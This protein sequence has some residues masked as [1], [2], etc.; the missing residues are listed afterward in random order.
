MISALIEE[1]KSIISFLV[2][3]P[4]SE[5]WGDLRARLF[6][7][8]H[9]TVG[10]QLSR[11]KNRSSSGDSVAAGALVGPQQHIVFAPVWGFSEKVIA[12]EA[13]LAMALRLRGHKVSVL[14]CGQALPACLWNVFGNRSLSTAGFSHRVSSAGRTAECRRCDELHSRAWPHTGVNTLSLL[15]YSDP[16]ALESAED[17]VN[18]VYEGFETDVHYKGVNIRE[19]AYAST[20]RKLTRGTLEYDAWS[21][22]LFKRFMI[23][24]VVYI[25][26]LEILISEQKPDVFVCVHGI[27]LEHGV[28]ADYAKLKGVRVVVHGTPYRKNTMWLSHDD[29]YHRTLV[30]E[31]NARW[32]NIALDENMSNAVHDYL[33]SKISGGRENVNFNPAPI[34]DSQAMF[35]EM[36][37]NPEKPTVALFTNTLW[38]AQVVYKSN[39]FEDMLDWLFA[40][41]DFFCS[42]SKVQLAVRIHPAESKAGFT[43]S[44]PIIEEIRK[45]YTRIPEHVAIVGPDS[46]ISS[47]LLSD[48]S[49]ASV[50]YGTK[51]GVELAYRK[52]IV[53]C[54][55]E[56][57]CRG[58]GFTID[59][60]TA[61]EYF[62][63]LANIETL[64]VN[65]E[66]FAERAK[67]YAYHL[68][69]NRMMDFTPVTVTDEMM[70]RRLTINIKEEAE[71]GDG[72]ISEIDTIC[73]GILYGTPFETFQ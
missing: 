8:G 28:L 71:L 48:E 32:E 70:N 6:L 39:A 41:I 47:V 7:G 10:R 56:S 69:F 17:F 20:L 2:I 9:A 3:Q 59:V 21:T 40:T 31:S 23:A 42:Q 26:A 33:S 34:L 54:A 61:R 58:K 66:R 30:T 53:I 11:I 51:L 67:K 45:R 35:D 13:V 43:T 64:T 60:E 65:L 62:E 14:R 4:I 57:I 46:D 63:V 12:D 49:V 24:A 18:S 72:K 27:Y 73:S 25:D 38:D 37:L 22:F 5:L 50:I 1:S 52:N 15:E 55:G 29:T 16:V 68:F 44:Q 36:Q 19:H